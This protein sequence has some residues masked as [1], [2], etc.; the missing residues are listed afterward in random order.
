MAGAVSVRGKKIRVSELG[1]R[2][3]IPMS[4]PQRAAEVKLLALTSDPCEPAFAS[5]PAP[6]WVREVT[7]QVEEFVLRRKPQSWIPSILEVRTLM[8]RLCELDEEDDTSVAKPTSFHEALESERGRRPVPRL[9]LVSG[10]A[11]QAHV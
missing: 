6:A 9:P 5:D 4:K 10:R 1:A 2:F 11:C 8:A 3:D 7:S